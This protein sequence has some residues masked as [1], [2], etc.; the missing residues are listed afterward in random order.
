MPRI[1]QITRSQTATDDSVRTTSHGSHGLKATDH[2]PRMTRITRISKTGSF[3]FGLGRTIA[4]SVA[5]R[6]AVEECGSARRA[7]RLLNGSPI[8][9]RLDSGLRPKFSRRPTPPP[10]QRTNESLVSPWLCADPALRH[11]G[12]RNHF[13]ESPLDATVSIVLEPC[14]PCDPWPFE[15]VVIRAIRGPFGSC[16]PYHPWPVWIR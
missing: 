10:R 9:S 12:D 13:C 7:G 11:E 1:T 3:R 16:D 6:S 15:T 4:S 2:A 14:E 8:T 5:G